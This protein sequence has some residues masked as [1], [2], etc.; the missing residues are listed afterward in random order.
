[1]FLRCLV[2]SILSIGFFAIATIWIL[3]ED[4]FFTFG[5]VDK[6]Y[7][8]FGTN[9]NDVWT[10]VVLNGWL[11]IWGV[12]MLWIVGWFDRWMS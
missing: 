3:G 11:L 1:M 12:G 4:V 10:V 5:F 6:L 7:S 9:P 8:N 2:L